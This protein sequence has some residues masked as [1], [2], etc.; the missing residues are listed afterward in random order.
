MA[1]A[2]RFSYVPSLDGADRLVALGFRHWVAGYQTSDIAC[3][4]QAWQLF[5]HEL[6]MKAARRIALKRRA[7]CA[8]SVSSNVKA[9][10]IQAAPRANRRAARWPR[11]ACT[12]RKAHSPATK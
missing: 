12:P 5:E 7:S 8:Q 9:A 10:M 3:W 1:G 4:E 11:A 6:G 2:A